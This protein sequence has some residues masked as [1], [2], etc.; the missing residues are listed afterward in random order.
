MQIQCLVK[1]K[2]RVDAVSVNAD[3]SLRI[4]IKAMP[5]DG[6]AN[7]YLV[8]YLSGVFGLPRKNI[9]IISGFTNS[10]K[11]VNIV[12]DEDVI[13]KKIELLRS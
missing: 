7:E 13:K 2:S 3:G 6:E 10:H 12:A 5:V 4:K 1:P 8:K 11:R 9:E